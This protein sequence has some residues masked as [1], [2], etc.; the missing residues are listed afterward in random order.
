MSSTQQQEGYRGYATHRSFG[1][2]QIPIPI[3]NLIFRDYCARNN[4]LFKLTSNEFN[5]PNC[6]LMLEKLL[7]E[8]PS[9]EGVIM[10]SVFLLPSEQEKRQEIYDL[11]FQHN[12]SLHFIFESTVIRTANDIDTIEDI[13]L[14]NQNLKNTPKNIPEELW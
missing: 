7:G 1:G 10:C 11:F 13:M 9:L 12:A 14:I 3:Q 4:L 6:Y 2:N 8:L 5:F